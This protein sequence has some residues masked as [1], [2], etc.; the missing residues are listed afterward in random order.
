MRETGLS[1]QRTVAYAAGMTDR[2]KMVLLL[3]GVFALPIAA[4]CGLYAGL[5]CFV[6]GAVLMLAIVGAS[7]KD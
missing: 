5:A 3:S 2:L 1:P 4:G 7:A 6:S